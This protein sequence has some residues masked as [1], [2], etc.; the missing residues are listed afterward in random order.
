MCRTGRRASCFQLRTRTRR[1]AS[2]WDSSPV[3][4]CW[5]Q[6]RR[7]PRRVLRGSRTGGFSRCTSDCTPTSYKEGLRCPASGARSIP[8]PRLAAGAS[9]QQPRIRLRREGTP[10]SVVPVE[11]TQHRLDTA[12]SSTVRSRSSFWRIARTCVS[13]VLAPP[14]GW[15]AIAELK[16]LFAFE[17]GADAG[18]VELRVPQ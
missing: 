6:C 2:R 17:W 10:Q 1:S 7:Q 11:P 15:L 5:P 14:H 4:Q 18:G 16:R 13:T 8:N 12:V 9:I 3:H